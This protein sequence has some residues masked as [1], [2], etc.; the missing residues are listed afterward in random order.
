MTREIE[1]AKITVYE[2]V[3]KIEKILAEYAAFNGLT[4]T[5]IATDILD[6]FDIPWGEKKEIKMFEDNVSAKYVDTVIKK[7]KDKGKTH[8]KIVLSSL[9]EGM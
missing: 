6:E 4:S 2:N 1:S 7:G 5:A 3:A 8:G 9:K